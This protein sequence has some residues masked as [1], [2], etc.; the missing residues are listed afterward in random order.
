VL[1]VVVGV[2]EVTGGWGSIVAQ[3]RDVAPGYRT[4]L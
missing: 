2:L 3:L 4:S 1:L